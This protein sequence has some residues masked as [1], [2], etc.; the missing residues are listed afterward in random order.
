MTLPIKVT[1]FT[2]GAC[3]GNPGRGGWAA[4]LYI[5]GTQH[6]EKGSEL[7]TTNN[8]ME[9]M[10]AIKGLEAAPSDKEVIIYSD[11]TYLVNTMTRNWKRNANQDLWERLDSLCKDRKVTWK[12]VRGH[13]GTPGNELA[14]QIA[15]REAG[16]FQQPSADEAEERLRPPSSLSR[17]PAGSRPASSSNG[18]Q[19]TRRPRP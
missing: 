16:L 19:R 4:V 7:R 13:N 12:W 6:I 9:L 3:K 10:A 8:R 5:N 2:D 15:S 14:D 1:I 11:S 18:F 17:R